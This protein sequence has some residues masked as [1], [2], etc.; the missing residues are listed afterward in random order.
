MSSLGSK[1]YDAFLSY[2]SQDRLAVQEVAGRL[3]GEKL[4]LYLEVWE[5]APGREFQPALAEALHDSKTCVVF[6]GPCGMRQRQ[7]QVVK[8][9]LDK[10]ELD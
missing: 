10:R 2:N 1:R 5:L 3:K 4:K 7:R 9:A 8:V 6:L